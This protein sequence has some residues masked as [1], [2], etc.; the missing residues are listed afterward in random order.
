MRLIKYFRPKPS[1]PSPTQKKNNQL[2]SM[3]QI[4]K[5]HLAKILKFF[6]SLHFLSFRKK[7]TKTR[8][9]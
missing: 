8:R 3:Y 9:P 4:Q 1:F 2:R 5:T 7:A 6:V